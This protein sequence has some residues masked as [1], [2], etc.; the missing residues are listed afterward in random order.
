M[1]SLMNKLSNKV[2]SNEYIIMAPSSFFLSFFVFFE[3][4]KL[5]EH[6]N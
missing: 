5:K 6:K 1:L 4:K 3:K 2:I